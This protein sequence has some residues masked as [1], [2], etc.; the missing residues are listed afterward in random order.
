MFQSH[1]TNAY[2]YVLTNDLLSTRHLSRDAFTDEWHISFS[3]AAPLSLFRYRSMLWNE[4]TGLDLALVTDGPKISGERVLETIG[5]RATNSDLS[6]LAL[7]CAGYWFL[8]LLIGVCRG[9]GRQLRL[10]GEGGRGA[11]CRCCF[12]AKGG[13]YRWSQRQ[14]VDRECG[15]AGAQRTTRTEGGTHGRQ[16]VEVVGG[17]SGGRG[18]A[19]AV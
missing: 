7:F 14:V 19:S 17:A 5:I 9:T 11:W 1:S 3:S 10:E 6:F 8:A 15:A 4:M 18:E 12:R 13:G 16:L 2:L